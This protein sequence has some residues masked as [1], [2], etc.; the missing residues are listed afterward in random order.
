MKIVKPLEESGLQIKGVSETIKNEVK[1]QKG[2]FL[3][4]LLG[5]LGASFSGNL[6]A[7]KG[8]VRASQD[9]LCCL[10]LQQIFKYKGITKWT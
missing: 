6:L 3:S 10:I 4:M 8:T 1:E 7:G 2:R 9:F 5:T